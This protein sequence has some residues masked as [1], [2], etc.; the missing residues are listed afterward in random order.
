VQ[1]AG[2]THEILA[3]LMGLRDVGQFRIEHAGERQQLVAL[4]LRATRSG[5]M[6]R[7]SSGSRRASS[8]TTKSNSSCRVVSAGPASAKMSWFNHWVNVGMSRANRSAWGSVCRACSYW[9]ACASSG[10]RWLA[11]SIRS[12]GFSHRE[13]APVAKRDSGLARPSHWCGM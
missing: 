7:T 6:R 4:A 8:A 11:R 2:F 5:R 3:D 9:I 12:L 10:S 1:H 13:A